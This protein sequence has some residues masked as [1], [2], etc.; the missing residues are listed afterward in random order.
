M[1]AF[2]IGLADSPKIASSIC[3]AIHSLAE[4]C[5]VDDTV[6]TTLLSK[7]LGGLSRALITTS[8]KGD[9]N[10]NLLVSSYEA[11]T[12]L[13]KNSAKDVVSEIC[14]FLGGFMERLANTLSHKAANS[15]LAF[16]QAQLQGYLCG[17]IQVCI[18]RII[19]L[20][21]VILYVNNR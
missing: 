7:Y 13:F 18:T 19:K 12:A 21:D 16:K 5:S 10:S 1:R 9:S 15:D 4:A 20:N 8:D 14:G 3:Y 2:E 17:V 11:I 6:E